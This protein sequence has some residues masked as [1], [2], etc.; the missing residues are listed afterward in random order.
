MFKFPIPATWQRAGSATLFLVLAACT[1][2]P[3]PTTELR[4]AQSAIES[5]EKPR[6]ADYLSEARNKLSTATDH[7]VD[8]AQ[9][10]A[11]TR[12][13][14]EQ[15]NLL[16]EQRA[17]SQPDAHTPQADLAYPETNDLNAQIAELN[18][19]EIERGQVGTSGD[20]QFETDKAELNGAAA[21]NLTRLAVV[22]NRDPDRNVIIAGYTDSIGSEAY[23]VNLSQQRAESVLGY[24]MRQG[25]AK[26]RMSAVGKGEI[27]PV[28]S[29]GDA[30]GRKT[31]RRVEV[32]I[33]NIVTARAYLINDWPISR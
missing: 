28:A 3:T 9:A 15:H 29:N 2:A 20:L 10:Q 6:L 32:I 11:Q 26:D 21:Y 31:N 13:W 27:S 7:I 23:N 14:V 22:L 1:V 12:L 25:I 4:A 16:S 8:N 24:L 17:D 19:R 30:L 5:A 33:T 18:D